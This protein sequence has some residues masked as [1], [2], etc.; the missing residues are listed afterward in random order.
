MNVLVVALKSRRLTEMVPAPGKKKPD[1][2]SRV[3][4]LMLL[5]P[6]RTSTQER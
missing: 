2:Q 4:K 6:R 1:S 5:A 3:V